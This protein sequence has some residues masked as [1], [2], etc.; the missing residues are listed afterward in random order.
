M[1]KVPEV[2]LPQLRK[3]VCSRLCG[4]TN[5]PLVS[6]VSPNQKVAPARDHVLAGNYIP[7]FV[8][9]KQQ[10]YRELLIIV[11]HMRPESHSKH[12]E[13]KNEGH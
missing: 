10:I 7:R 6:H 12:E 3:S 11:S 8:V 5:G 2:I 13:S 9:S 4:C 1:D